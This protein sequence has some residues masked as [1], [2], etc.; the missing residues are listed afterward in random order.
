MRL[1]IFIILLLLAIPARAANPSFNV[2]NTNDFWNPVQ[3]SAIKLMGTTTITTNSTTADIQAAF[4]RGQ[5]VVFMPGLYNITTNLQLTNNLVIDGNYAILQRN[6]GL[7]NY[8]I[9]WGNNTNIFI[10]NLIIDGRFRTLAYSQVVSN[11]MGIRVNMFNG[12]GLFNVTVQNMMGYGLAPFN[13]SD[14]GSFTNNQTAIV[15]YQA[16]AVTYGV[17]LDAF[18]NSPEYSVFTGAKI[19]NCFSGVYAMSGN[20]NFIGGTITRNRCGVDFTGGGNNEAHGI[21][22]GTQFNHNDYAVLGNGI[23]P[24]ELFVGCQFLGGGP[25]NIQSAILMTNCNGFQFVG[26]KFGAMVVSSTNTTGARTINQF[27]GCTYDGLW[28]SQ[29][30]SNLDRSLHFVD[31]MS[32][33]TNDVHQWEREG[34]LTTGLLKYRLAFRD[35]IIATASTNQLMV[36]ATNAEAAGSSTWFPNG[37]VPLSVD[38]AAADNFPNYGLRLGNYAANGSLGPGYYLGRDNGNGFFHI[39]GQQGSLSEVW[40]ESTLGSVNPYFVAAAVEGVYTVG[41]YSGSKGANVSSA[42]TISPSGMIF[43]VTGTTTIQTINLPYAD[44]SANYNFRGSI[45]IIPDGIFATTTGGNIAIASTAVVGKA[46]IMTWDGTSWY[47]SY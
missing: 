9:D 10:R 41:Y 26:C 12:G 46:L 4:Y 37:L 36:G 8:I 40:F 6:H 32:Y 42:T 30:I 5:R 11:C 15:D 44:G 31:C 47:P 43:H 22:N 33:Q 35:T 45:T 20:H 13:V 28:Q 24:G 16:D 25:N 38:S 18:A 34:G 7:T 19:H 29:T 21:F 2:F 23:R 1:L 17:F 14:S 27:V 39:G 3:T